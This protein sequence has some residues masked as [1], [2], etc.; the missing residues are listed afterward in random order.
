MRTP[1]RRII[2]LIAI[3]ATA[4]CEYCFGGGRG[5]VT[6]PRALVSCLPLPGTTMGVTV[7]GIG[8]NPV[9]LGMTDFTTTA[10]I[11]NP[12]DTT[13]TWSTGGT[14]DPGNP[15]TGTSGTGKV[16]V[17][18]PVSVPDSIALNVTY[19]V[20]GVTITISGMLRPPPPC[21]GSGTWSA[22]GAGGLSLGNGTWT[23]P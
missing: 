9:T 19:I 13:V 2:L 11:T 15:I 14:A 16:T 3:A 18:G 7:S 5:T 10:T 12:S 4:S 21:T 23:I 20:D 1:V 22:T 17:Y 6:V 8:V